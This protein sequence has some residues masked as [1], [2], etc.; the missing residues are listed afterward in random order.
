MC[1]FV[2]QRDV[3]SHIMSKDATQ[4]QADRTCN[5]LDTISCCWVCIALTPC[6]IRLVAV[7]AC[8]SAPPNLTSSS[9]SAELSINP[10]AAR[11]CRML[12]GCNFMSFVKFLAAFSARAS[13][14]AKRRFLF[15]A[16][17][18]S[19]L[20]LC[21]VHSLLECTYERYNRTEMLTCICSDNSL[22][23]VRLCAVYITHPLVCLHTSGSLH[24]KTIPADIS[25]AHMRLDLSACSLVSNTAPSCPR[26]IDHRIL[27]TDRMRDRF[28]FC[29]P[30]IPA[31]L[32][33]STPSIT[34]SDAALMLSAL[35]ES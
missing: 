15:Q 6:T 20:S 4:W 31:R 12:D 5:N 27:M 16:W 11:I 14:D 24:N 19:I 8:M 23:P 13:V 22:M 32:P 9:V 30:P 1:R 3:C 33:V 18:I 2:R 29:I 17:P 26:A 35:T 21:S 34:H 28:H 7:S 25:H 10:L